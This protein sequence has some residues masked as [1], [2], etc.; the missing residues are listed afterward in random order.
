MNNN[1]QVVVHHFLKT[2]S[3]Y[4]DGRVLKWTEFLN[5]AGYKSIVSVIEDSNSKNVQTQ[6]QVLVET[7]KL[8][9]RKIFPK[10]KGYFFK[11]IEYLFLVL[12][13][14][15]KY[16][17]SDILVFHDV[18]Q[19]LNLFVLIFFNLKRGK[20]IIW[21]LHELPHTFLEKFQLTRNFIR[22]LI[23]RVDLVIYTNNE[24]KDYIRKKYFIQKEKSYFVLNN[25]PNNSYN[26]M[27]HCELE[28]EIVDWLEDKPYV[29]WMG[30]ANE[31][32]NFTTFL[33]SYKKVQNKYKLIIIGNIDKKYKEA[34][35][36]LKRENS[37]FNKFVLQNEIIKYVDNASFSVVLYNASSPNNYLCEPNRLYQLINRSVPAIVG[38][39]PTLKKVI[40]ASK[41]GIVLPDS[42]TFEQ[43]MD[44]AFAE[45]FA[46][47]DHIKSNLEQSDVR[48]QFSWD[49]QFNILLHH[50]HNLKN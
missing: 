27:Q 30:A 10:R 6:N 9:F 23:N 31:A 2:V 36:N 16:K 33:N 40:D 5:K 21:D 43:D 17:K 48:N 22:Y 13:Q 18:Q 28:P 3:F 39:N 1:K 25:Y 50:I 45:M 15:K 19:Y 37:L 24:R 42:G 49:N 11:I 38:S 7:Q 4:T 34:T 35:E 41:G 12:G 29:L 47:V 44:R 14:I 46:K 8:W 32:R 20:K 26:T